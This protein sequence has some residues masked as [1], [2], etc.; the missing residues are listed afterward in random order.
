[1][2]FIFLERLT[3]PCRLP[4]RNLTGELSEALPEFSQ[5]QAGESAGS[6]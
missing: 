5:N 2:A 6:G 3:V 1:M 4:N